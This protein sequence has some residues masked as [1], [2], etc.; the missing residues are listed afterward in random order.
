MPR[1]SNKRLPDLDLLREV[2]HYDKLTGDFVWKK[3]TSPQSPVRVGDSAGWAGNHGRLMITID[4]KDYHASR[5]AWYMET[6]RDPGDMVIDH[7]NGLVW[8]NRLSN[9]RMVTG[10]ENARNVKRHNRS[11][12]LMGVTTD[13]HGK[14]VSRLG[15][16]YLG[17]FDDFFEAACC[18][19]SAQN[20]MGYHANHGRA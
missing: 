14:Y 4:R 17:Y 7:I 16:K 2:L 15:Q 8:D 6:G 20:A 5:I 12:R 19:L 3:K 11:G 9:L 18:R 13:K 1:V 10:T